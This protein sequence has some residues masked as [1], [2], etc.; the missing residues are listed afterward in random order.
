MKLHV[1]WYTTGK[2]YQ[3]NLMQ[4]SDKKTVSLGEGIKDAS[5]DILLGV[6]ANFLLR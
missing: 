3:N 4:F 2:L 6:E 5:P 1:S